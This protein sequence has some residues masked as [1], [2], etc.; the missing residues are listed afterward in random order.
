NAKGLEFENIFVSGMEEGLFPH[1]NSFETEDGLEEERRLFYV[2]M[3]RAKKH[4]YITYANS[5]N[6]YGNRTINGV[7]MFLNELPVKGTDNEFTFSH[8]QKITIK[9]KKGEKQKKG[10]MLFNINEVVIHPFWGN[11]VITGI[12]GSGDNTIANIRFYSVGIKKIYV[13]YANLQRKDK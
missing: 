12:K 4:L 10:K 3:T 6:H 5:R 2:A 9:D 11:G 7:S 13:K 1:I 8:N